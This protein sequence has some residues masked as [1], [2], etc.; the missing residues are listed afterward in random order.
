MNFPCDLE[1]SFHSGLLNSSTH[2]DT[3]SNHTERK[4]ST[5]AAGAS[6]VVPTISDDPIP[7]TTTGN[8]LEQEF[9]SKPAVKH[10]SLVPVPAQT[11]SVLPL[12]FYPRRKTGQPM[13][14][15]RKVASSR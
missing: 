8:D 6:A 4:S 15:R 2:S 1:S 13:Q 7:S 3:P 5:P 14:K 11:D 12:L 10:S 9:Y